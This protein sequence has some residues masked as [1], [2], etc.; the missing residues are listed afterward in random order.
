MRVERERLAQDRARQPPGLVPLGQEGTAGEQRQARRPGSPPPRAASCL[1]RRHRRAPP[2]R[3]RR[4]LRAAG[5]APRRGRR[6]P[7]PRTSGPARPRDR[8]SGVA[9]RP[10]AAVRLARAGS[11]AQQRLSGP[12]PLRRRVDAQL[13]AQPARNGPAPPA[14]RP[15]TRRRQ[16]LSVH[17]SHGLAQRVSRHRVGRATGRAGASSRATAARAAVSSTSPRAL[18]RRSRGRGPTRRSVLGQRLTPQPQRLGAVVRRIR[19]LGPRA[20]PAAPAPTRPRNSTTRR[21][22]TAPARSRR[23]RSPRPRGG[24]QPGRARVT[25]TAR[26]ADGSAG[27]WSG[28]SDS[29]RTS[30]G[31]SPAAHRQHPQQRADLAA[32][33][34]RRRHLLAVAAHLEPP[35]QL[36]GHVGHGAIV[37]ARRRTASN[38]QSRVPTVAATTSEEAR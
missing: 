32:A 34:R 7:G 23:P 20:A 24:D 3:R 25:S 28:H 12:G 22:R 19:G 16:R 35:Q 14:P 9:E 15:V 17:Q 11:P 5:R 26:F 36:Q 30:Y 21:P 29:A 8:G 13:V 1:H 18:S 33:E 6:R 31:T 10:S 2:R 38:P 4:S 27:W 37:L